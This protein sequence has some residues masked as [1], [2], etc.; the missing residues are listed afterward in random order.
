MQPAAA[1]PTWLPAGE[2]ETVAAA[3]SYSC[4][5]HSCR[6]RSAVLVEIGKPET[7]DDDETVGQ[8]H[9]HVLPEELDVSRELLPEHLVVQQTFPHTNP[10]AAT[11]DVVDRVALAAL[12]RRSR[13][14]IMGDAVQAP[15]RDR[16]PD[17]CGDAHRERT[18][19]GGAS[20]AIHA[21]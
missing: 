4:P 8:L 3:R 21:V 18:P 16:H 9:L 7:H 5:A 11:P 15:R 2:R 1:T 6:P 17:A 12:G 10:I 19:R 14:A 13:P 20:S